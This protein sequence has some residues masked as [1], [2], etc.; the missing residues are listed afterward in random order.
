MID[1]ISISNIA[2]IN[3]ATIRLS[4]GLTAITGETGAGKTA[5]LNSCR[6]ITGQRA[7]KSMI[8]EGENEASVT[9]RV[10]IE[11]ATESA[12]DKS[13]ESDEFDTSDEF[14][15]SCG[16][17]KE[18]HVE[19]MVVV[20][21]ISQDGRSRV[22]INGEMASVG[23]LASEIG[24]S[25]DL[26]GQHDQRLLTSPATQRDIL[27][28]WAGDDVLSKRQK[29][30]ELF[31]LRDEKRAKLDELIER[32]NT[33]EDRLEQA[34]F[35]LRQIDAIEPS[36]DDYSDLMATL[37]KSENAEVLARL[38]N[39]AYDALSGEQQ[40]LDCLNAAVQFLDDASKSDAGLMQYADSL[41]EATYILE[42]VS[43]DVLGYRDA[44]DLDI[45]TLEAMQARAASYQSLIRQYG[46]TIEDLIAKAEDFREIVT[47]S[48]GDS[49]ALQ[50]A[51][52]E[53]KQVEEDLNIAAN[54]FTEARL[55]ASPELCAEIGKVMSEL[56]MGSAD[57]TCDVS[58]LPKNEWTAS[59][60]DKV[61]FLF[62]AASGMQP[63]P[64]ARVASGGELSRI[65][66]ALHVVMG[67]RDQVSTLVFDEIDAGVG[68]NT[69]RALADVLSGLAK[70]HQVIV[71]THLAQIAAAA[72]SHY[73]VTK[74][75]NAGIATTTIE[76]VSG[77]DRI[78]E[79]ARMLSGSKTEASIKH[80]EE[81]LAG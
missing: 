45:E 33:S 64:L 12:F 80:A 35:A 8:R 61:E 11:D 17:E 52:A 48:S 69:A 28:N 65:M 70:T 1:E 74:T 44:V 18:T 72:E 60:P 47:L 2:L 51:E 13:S 71:V 50:E 10:F 57:I 63:R 42:D 16:F 23:E 58:Q 22:K 20:R 6:L 21:T 81:L 7:E 31:A 55:T 77:Q 27:D 54:A 32:K 73:V 34:V 14:D 56:E 39:E 4:D 43:R 19:E 79:V 62:R 68:G 66:L 49:E 36:I 59:S 46:P 40:A 67:N 24:G 5:L 76:Q 75:E 26:S 9:A 37:K 15:M 41:R 53:L 78:E 29:Y 38:T 25:I 30:S 3:K